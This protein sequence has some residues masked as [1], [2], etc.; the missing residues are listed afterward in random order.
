MNPILA[1]YSSGATLAYTTLVQ[2]PPGTFKGAL[3]LGFCPD[4]PWDKPMCPG[5]GPGLA[6]DRGRRE[7][8]VFRPVHGLKDPWIALQG[9][10]DQVC[11]AGVTRSFVG[12]VPGA[13]LIELPK[14]GHGFSV[15]RNYVTQMMAAFDRLAAV[16]PPH[17]A[18]AAATSPTCRWSR[19]RPP[20][21]RRT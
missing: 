6:A 12:K 14:V 2:S 17:A 10:I 18:A 19:C 21:R 5:D 3:S 7:G 20:A 9:T 11:D 8:Y 4:L 13:E 1:G 15:E 16:K